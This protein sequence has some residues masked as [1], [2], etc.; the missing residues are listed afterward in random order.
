VLHL[1]VD[2]SVFELK[3]GGA[4]GEAGEQVWRENG[5]AV[6]PYLAMKGTEPV[7]CRTR[8]KI[9]VPTLVV[10]GAD[11]FTRFSMMAESVGN[12]VANGLTL[13]MPGVNHDGPYRQPE[14]F[15]FLIR[16]FIALTE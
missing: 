10:Q 11:S 16:S 8:G 1:L 13:T 2:S 15:A 3:D 9:R 14:K 12:C 4:V 7:D 6:G 5:R